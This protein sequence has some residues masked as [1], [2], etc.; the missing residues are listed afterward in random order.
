MNRFPQD[1]EN[2]AQSILADEVRLL[3]D[4][5]TLPRHMARALCKVFSGVAREIAED[6]PTAGRNIFREAFTVFYND[7][8]WDRRIRRQW[9]A[10]LPKREKHL[11]RKDDI[12]PTDRT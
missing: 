3:L 4:E 6:D 10:T 12:P 2:Q 9:R 5:G 7:K 8:L 11:A 1:H